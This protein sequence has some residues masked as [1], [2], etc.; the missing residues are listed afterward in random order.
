M[1]CNGAPGAP[2]VP[3]PRPSRARA[4]GARPPT[5]R[6][7][8]PRSGETPAAPPLAWRTHPEVSLV[9]SLL[10]KTVLR[11]YRCIKTVWSTKS[12]VAEL[13]PDEERLPQLLHL[14]AHLIVVSL[15]S[16]GVN[17]CHPQRIGRHPYHPDSR[18]LLLI[19]PP[20]TPLTCPAL[21]AA[22]AGWPGRR[23]RAKGR[24]LGGGAASA[25]PA[26]SRARGG[27]AP[28]PHRASGSRG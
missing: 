17:L 1:M 10:S 12:Y 19:L 27:A 3:G 14:P 7:A 20:M 18:L 9:V 21:A 22:R 11:R 25:P 23:P 6:G 24:R 4:P 2:V 5:T 15:S 26:R 13:I 28:S 16:I 8:G